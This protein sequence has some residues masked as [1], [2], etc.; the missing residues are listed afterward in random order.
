MSIFSFTDDNVSKY[1][2]LYT[3]LG[4]CIDIVEIWYGIANGQISWQSYLPEYFHF[5]SIRSKSHLI[6]ALILWR[7]VLRLL[8]GKFSKFVLELSAHD[9]IMERYY[10]FMFYYL[11]IWYTSALVNSF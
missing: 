6:C 5:R 7:F 10:R 3:K 8:M 2:W 1:Q 9:M 4:M 11:N